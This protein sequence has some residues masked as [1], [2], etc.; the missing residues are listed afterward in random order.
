MQLAKRCESVLNE[1]ETLDVNSIA[2]IMYILSPGSHKKK[3][4]THCKSN[5]MFERSPIIIISGYVHPF[6]NSYLMEAFHALIKQGQK[7]FWS[8]STS[9]KPSETRIVTERNS[10]LDTPHSWS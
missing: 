2:V 6:R 5:K 3:H 4:K 1:C 8:P 9:T 10:N 7:V